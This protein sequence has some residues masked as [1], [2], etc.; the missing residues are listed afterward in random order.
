MLYVMPIYI[1]GNFNEEKYCFLFESDFNIDTKLLLMQPS[2]A[3]SICNK[4]KVNIILS[5]TSFKYS[6]DIKHSII[7]LIVFPDDD[8]A[9]YDNIGIEEDF[10]TMQTLSPIAQQQLMDSKNENDI[11]LLNILK[12]SLE[13]IEHLSSD[14]KV[15][16]TK[17][18][19]MDDELYEKMK[20]QKPNYDLLETKNIS[21]F[22]KSSISPIC[23]A[24]PTIDCIMS[25]KTNINDTDILKLVAP[26]RKIDTKR[27]IA[28]YLSQFHTPFFRL[29]SIDVNTIGSTE[30]R[31]RLPSSFSW[32]YGMSKNNL[33]DIQDNE[34]QMF[35]NMY[36]LYCY[37]ICINLKSILDSLLEYTIF[38]KK[39]QGFIGK[40]K[41]Q[42]LDNIDLILKDIPEYI[43]CTFD[44]AKIDLLPNNFILNIQFMHSLFH[45]SL[46]I[47]NKG[48]ISLIKSFENNT[49]IIDI[50][51]SYFNLN[52][53]ENIDEPK[54]I[55]ILIKDGFIT[56]H[57]FEFYMTLCKYA[58]RINWGHNG[59]TDAINELISERTR[60][61]FDQDMSK[62]LGSVMFSR[63]VE[64]IFNQIPYENLDNDDDDISDNFDEDEISVSV[65]GYISQVTFSKLAQ[66]GS[67]I[68]LKT[69]EGA[70]NTATV[71]EKIV[72]RWRVNRGE[73]SLTSFIKKAFIAIKD[74]KFIINTF[75]K[76]L[77]WGEERKPTILVYPEYPKLTYIFNL[78]A[79]TID[80]NNFIVDEK[81]LIKK[82]GCTYSLETILISKSKLLNVNFPIIVGFLL[83]KDYGSIKKYFI[84]SWSDLYELTC[85]DN[86]DITEFK[87][88]QNNIS[89]FREKVNYI[90]DM[91]EINYSF[92][93]SDSN[94]KSSNK[95]KCQASELSECALL[96]KENITST[97]EYRQAIKNSM[98]TTTTDIQYKIL[99]TY[100]KKLGEFY[101]NYSNKINTFSTAK[102]FL[103]IINLWGNINNM[104]V[105]TSPIPPAENYLKKMSFKKNINSDSKYINV[106]IC[107]CSLISDL[108]ME[109]NLTNITF[110]DTTLQAIANCTKNRV[111]L[112]LSEVIYNDEKVFVFSKDDT[113]TIKDM[114]IVEKDGKKLVSNYTFPMVAQILNNIKQT[115]ETIEN[116]KKYLL[117]I[118]LK[119][120]I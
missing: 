110:K 104:P 51:H 41:E 83:Y 30:D 92:Y 84:V 74:T 36:Q 75:I 4:Y 96:L 62:Y 91:K 15:M 44:K 86:I 13:Y 47:D 42:L 38:G 3:K 82:D 46:S 77:R 26:Y 78:N 34:K 80:F 76:L 120:F 48:I 12:M 90:E 8:S 108:K 57:L 56:K 9:D 94:I 11:T 93:I 63:E 73:Y 35:D 24:L 6:N 14:T 64:S 28:S 105:V 10:V 100:I 54:I 16:L 27:K 18:F 88:P 89:L 53:N 40:S 113:I 81:N 17:E 39:L 101:Q 55:E 20:F 67:T 66:S 112:L 102:E 31:K 115:G 19:F 68:D 52:I 61:Y 21:I 119:G 87:V 70:L 37:D 71:D 117:H 114:K 32:L 65:P 25:G 97:S 59:M 85:L 50:Q 29:G 103:S 118:S 2:I 49:H 109:S 111:V 33:L 60:E 69:G 106:N 72:E 116:G 23:I 107:N 43:I 95:Y 79:A 98:G 45:N 1:N 22:Q 5:E 7:P 99:Y 58:Y